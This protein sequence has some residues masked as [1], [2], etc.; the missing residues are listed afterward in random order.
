[1]NT[2]HLIDPI[3]VRKFLT[4]FHALAARAF[5]GVRRPGCVQLC[6]LIPD[7][8][9]MLTSAFNLGDIEAMSEAT[10][11]SAEGGAN[12]FCE[13]RSVRN[14][15]RWERQK[16]YASLG[17]FAIAVDND[18]D[19]NRAGPLIDNASITVGTSADTG[20]THQWFFLKH[21]LTVDA[22][23]AVGDQVRRL[24]KA[25]ACSGVI[26]GCY[27]IAGSPCFVDQIKKD[28]GRVTTPTRLINVTDKLWDA[29][30]LIAAF[31]KRT[32]RRN[33]LLELKVSRPA[34]PAMDRSSVFMSCVHMSVAC[35]MSAGD[36]EALMRQHPDGCAQKYLENG[37]RL[38]AEI[39]RAWAKAKP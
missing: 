32:P 9:R 23:K 5:D 2:D 8:R 35:G 11:I 6:S 24:S 26:T 30:E 18:V 33:S 15:Y 27:R 22:A 1:M 20:N 38:Q 29:D 10:V 7:Q 3:A 16:A 19:R 25:D 34:T 28:R 17:V 13:T 39:Q 21:A 14:G 12:C 31:S 36:L 4:A 37:D